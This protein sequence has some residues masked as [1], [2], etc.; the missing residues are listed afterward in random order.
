MQD[1]TLL[2]VACNALL[3]CAPSFLLAIAHALYLGPAPGCPSE[4][5]GNSIHVWEKGS[6]VDAQ[7]I[8]IT[9]NQIPVANNSK[10]EIR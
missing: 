5:F 6:P 4:V 7:G 1:K 2:P 3:G 10:G 9:Q 8:E